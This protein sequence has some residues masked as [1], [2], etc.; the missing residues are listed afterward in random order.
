MKTGSLSPTLSRRRWRALGVGCLVLLAGGFTWSFQ[1]TWAIR[2]AL[3]PEPDLAGKPGVLVDEIASA[4]ASARRWGFRQA[5]PLAKLAALYHANGFFAEAGACYR[6]LAKL[7]PRDPRWPHLLAQLEAS[8]GRLD[9]ALPWEETAARLAPDNALVQLRLGDLRFKDNHTSAAEHAYQR[10]R[11][12]APGNP[13]ALLGLARCALRR[14]DW[15]AARDLLR[16]AVA[17]QATFTAGWSLLA[18]VEAHLGLASASAQARV[19]GNG[20]FREPADPW[21]TALNEFC[22]DPYTLSVAAA[23]APD[24]A[25]ACALLERAIALAPEEAAYHR[26]L[27]KRL[28]AARDP[29]GARAQLEQAVK[30]APDDAE[31]W[32]SLVELLLDT[33]ELRAA[34]AALA[35]GLRRC[36]QSGFLHFTNGRRLAAT[37]RPAEAETEFRHSIALQPTEVRGYVELSTL[38]IRADRVADATKTIESAY[39]VDPANVTVMGLLA[40]LAILRRDAPAAEKWA[41]KI[42]ELP[43]DESATLASIRAAYAQQFGRPLPD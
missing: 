36:P 26:Q 29:G 1:R 17:A 32:S 10:A 34:M 27:A 23:V 28:I 18:S 31:A 16:G 20:Q 15:N 33:R 35:E 5:A 38:Y 43:T 7:E 12:L 41:A 8:F 40:Q 3:P 24:P 37:G 25:A 13:H 2:A 6:V 14:D 39:A 4:A 19:R 42:R 21:L 11:E 30:L 22:Y 9:T